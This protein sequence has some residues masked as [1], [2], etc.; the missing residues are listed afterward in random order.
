MMP[1]G[2]RLRSHGWDFLQRVPV[3]HPWATGSYSDV[4]S[5][6]DRG[7]IDRAVV[8]QSYMVLPQLGRARATDAPQYYNPTRVVHPT[9][10]CIGSLRGALSPQPVFCTSRG[11]WAAQHM[12]RLNSFDTN[13]CLNGVSRSDFFVGLRLYGNRSK[14]KNQILPSE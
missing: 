8:W 10:R 9:L 11:W 13:W 1:T 5:A 4:A 14:I 7:P 3:T 2:L 6:R 12:L